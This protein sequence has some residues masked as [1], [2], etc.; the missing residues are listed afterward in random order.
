MRRENY[1][2][3]CDVYPDYEI[4]CVITE[5]PKKHEK[6]Y[7]DALCGGISM[8]CCFS[9]SNG[10]V[11]SKQRATDAILQDLDSSSNPYFRVLRNR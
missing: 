2:R 9:T 7:D 5:P 11:G 10:G 1:K 4:E 8:S 3:L 6:N